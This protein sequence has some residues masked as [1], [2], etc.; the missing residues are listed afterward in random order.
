MKYW[1]IKSEPDV[2]SW[3]Q[4]VKDGIAIWD[5]VRNYQAR[6]Y[7]KEMTVGDKV[8][9]YHSNKDRAVVGKA[10]VARTAYPDPTIKDDR[11]VAVDI[12]PEKKLKKAITL[13]EIKEDEFLKDILLIKQ[14][15]LSVMP[16][17]HEEFQRICILAEEKE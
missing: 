16:L 9:F 7:M 14:S 4:L 13:I 5:G 3:M 2:Y 1:L 10:V 11:W 6:N 15:R 12:K 17:K 8:L